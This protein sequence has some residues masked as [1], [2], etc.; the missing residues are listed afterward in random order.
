MLARE[1]H[2]LRVS[3]RHGD[4]YLL[5]CKHSG[6]TCK[7]RIL[8]KIVKTDLCLVYDVM[9]VLNRSVF[10]LLCLDLFDH[11]HVELFQNLKILLLLFPLLL[12]DCNRIIKELF[13]SHTFRGR[14]RRL[15]QK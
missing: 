15:F 10:I 1:Q 12:T 8:N 13:E 2:Y 7:F 3:V 6:S 14:Q 5:V 11:T 4:L 9:Q